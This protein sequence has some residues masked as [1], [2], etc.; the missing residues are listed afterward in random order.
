MRTYSA[1]RNF[2]T[3]RPALGAARHFSANEEVTQLKVLI[4]LMQEGRCGSECQLAL[5]ES[6]S[7]VLQ[8]VK[9]GEL[10]L[11]HEPDADGT[12]SLPP[13]DDEH[14]LRAALYWTVELR[15]PFERVVEAC[16]RV[17]DRASPAS[18]RKAIK[19]IEFE[20]R[21]CETDA[22]FSMPPS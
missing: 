9:R 13:L 12:V 6:F 17:G 1:L 19:Q 18:V 3:A 10:L 15:A 5:A 11:N 21:T 20:D 16:R 14:Y 22:F 2:A 4:A 8:A 7:S